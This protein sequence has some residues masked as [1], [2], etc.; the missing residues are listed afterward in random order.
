[1]LNLFSTQFCG[2]DRRKTQAINLTGIFK[3]NTSIYTIL[4][5]GDRHLQKASTARIHLKSKKKK[6]LHKRK[7]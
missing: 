1:M 2:E 7:A 3:L 5:W 4:K 6:R